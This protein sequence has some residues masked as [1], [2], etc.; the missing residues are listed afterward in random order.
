VK[1]QFAKPFFLLINAEVQFLAAE[2]K[3]RYGAA[4]TT[5]TGTAQ[6]Y[7]EQGVKESFRLTGTAASA[8]TTLLT[9]GIDMADWT[10]STDK[11]KAIWMQKWIALTNFS[12]LEA[13]SEYRRTNWP[14][15][16]QSA[17]V[18]AGSTDRPVRLFYPG[19]ELGSNRANVES[20]GAI[21]V[22]KTRLFWDVD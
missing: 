9:S 20:Q 2:A 7:Y 10:A 1:G 4:V 18:A 3:Q 6:S 16:P 17:S 13:W 21:N 15:T 19:T 5:L 11:L 12:G 22:F 8:A 14:A